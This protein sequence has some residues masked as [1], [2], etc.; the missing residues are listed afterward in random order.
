MKWWLILH[1]LLLRKRSRI[2]IKNGHIPFRNFLHPIAAIASTRNRVHVTYTPRG[3]LHRP[4]G[5]A[6][7]IKG[8]DPFLRRLTKCR[9]SSAL[10]PVRRLSNSAPKAS[11]LSNKVSMQWC[12]V[13]G[14]LERIVSGTPLLPFCKRNAQ[15]LE[16]C[17]RI[18]WV[19]EANVRVGKKMPDCFRDDRTKRRRSLN[20][21]RQRTAVIHKRR[22]VCF[23]RRHAHS[24]HAD[25]RDQALA[26]RDFQTFHVRDSLSQPDR[27]NY[28]GTPSQIQCLHNAYMERR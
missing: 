28:R 11:A 2:S 12:E 27:A 7:S 24:Q 23:R 5:S 26:C 10:S 21:L 14:P 3:Q 16:L 25:R 18:P 4:L 6:P 22:Q 9:W 1:P 13:P 19:F 8:R 20:V 15:T 17:L